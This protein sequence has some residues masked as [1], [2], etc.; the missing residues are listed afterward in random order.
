M[1]LGAVFE[2]CGCQSLQQSSLLITF[3]KNPH[4]AERPKAILES[5][6]PPS[7]GKRKIVSYHIVKCQ[8]KERKRLPCK[9]WELFK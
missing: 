5:V 6:I 4:C 9:H 2:K 8:E 3:E 1:V 7:L